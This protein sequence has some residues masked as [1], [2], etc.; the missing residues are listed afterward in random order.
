MTLRPAPHDEAALARLARQWGVS[1]QQ[2]ALRAIREAAARLDEDVLALS[3]V[4]AAEDAEALRRL[5]E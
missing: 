5:G 2:A 3:D 4:L 1:K